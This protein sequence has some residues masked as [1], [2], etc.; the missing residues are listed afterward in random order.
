MP[1][2]QL[3]VGDGDDLVGIL[4][5]LVKSHLIVRAQNMAQKIYQQCIVPPNLFIHTIFLLL[6]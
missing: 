5:Q 4:C 1:A 6:R 3:A 2:R